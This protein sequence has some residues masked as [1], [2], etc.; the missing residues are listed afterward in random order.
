MNLVVIVLALT[1]AVG[2]IAFAASREPLTGTAADTSSTSNTRALLIADNMNRR[3]LITTTAGKVLWQWKNPTG[4]TSK[5]SGPLGVR[6][7]GLGRVLATFGT[8]E[9][10]VI[11]L[12]SKSFVWVTNEMGSTY[13]LSPYDAMLLPEG[14]VAVASSKTNGGE[15]AVYDRATEK[16][17][18]RVPW[19]NAHALYFRQRPSGDE[20]VVGGRDGLAA[21]TYEPGVEPKMLWHRNVGYVHDIVAAPDRTLLL[22]TGTGNLRTDW[23]GAVLWRRD[24]PPGEKFRRV[25]VDP[26]EPT[27]EAVAGGSQNNIQ[28]R[29]VIDGSLLRQWSWLSDGTKLNWPYGIQFVPLAEAPRD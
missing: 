8:G 21:F 27:T 14:R 6:W 3:L 15:V 25:A 11:D 23:D 22:Q 12:T 24:N 1:L 5:Y 19:R 2:G 7:L 9:V 29:S 13:F 18:W 10:G 17:V 20:I 16:L 28:F 4:N 26:D